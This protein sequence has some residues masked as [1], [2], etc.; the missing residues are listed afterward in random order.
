MLSF[1]ANI[2]LLRKRKGRTQADVAQALEI[3]RSTLSGYENR[4][5][6]P[7]LKMLVAF[8]DY[9]QVAI[10]SLV[11]VDLAKL[12]ESQLS[13]LERGYDVFLKGS[14]IRVL[15][16]TVDAENNENIELVP[17]KAKA[18]YQR[19]FA[20][21]QFIS[22]LPVFQL[23]F[24]P[25]DKKFRT[26]QISGDSM[27]PI[28]DGAYVT[29]QYVLNWLDVRNGQAY[30][31]VTLD[32]GV[33]FKLVENKLEQEQKFILH[34]LNPLYEPYDIPVGQI[35]EVWR[36]THFISSELPEAEVPEEHL[37]QT[38]AQLKQDVNLLKQ[39]LKKD[40]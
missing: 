5:A 24:L 1:G 13:Q 16:T 25:R 6:E 30:L 34:S 10:D 3:K 32:D 27:Y 9:F 40:E 20:D 15:A 28:P 11:K 29:G 22:S 7:D 19:G 23:P 39:H 18:G 38:V 12:S 36:F 37:V 14:N 8:S 17:E 4:V 31:I 2:K 35:K 26:F 33:V 21:P